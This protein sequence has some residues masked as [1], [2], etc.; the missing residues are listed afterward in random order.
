MIK[1]KRKR[2]KRW[3]STTMCTYFFLSVASLCLMIPWCGTCMYKLSNL[4]PSP[5]F[6][7]LC[8]E[9][10][11]NTWYAQYQVYRCRE[12][13]Q[14]YRYPLIILVFE[15]NPQLFFDLLSVCVLTRLS[16]PCVMGKSSVLYSLPVQNGRWMEG[17]DG[18]SLPSTPPRL[19]CEGK[20]EWRR[21]LEPRRPAL[22]GTRRRWRRSRRRSSP[23]APRPVSP[24]QR[25][26][27]SRCPW[28]KR[29]AV[30]DRRPGRVRGPAGRRDGPWL[31][32][33]CGEVSGLREMACGS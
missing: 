18:R 6:V 29:C 9:S 4:K 2:K 11:Y 15:K 19:G 24:D 31:G 3:T 10:N 25:P 5:M 17:G 1:K 22:W 13:F 26:L 28:T 30:N 12:F 33:W 20:A 8:I 14:S 7:Y 16:S 27:R 23:A 21:A 32:C